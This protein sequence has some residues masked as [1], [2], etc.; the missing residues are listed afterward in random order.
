[1]IKRLN[2][3]KRQTNYLVCNIEV[4]NLNVEE[5]DGEHQSSAGTIKLFDYLDEMG[6][7]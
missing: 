5:D 3:A 7:R 1:M 4:P 6:E 2:N